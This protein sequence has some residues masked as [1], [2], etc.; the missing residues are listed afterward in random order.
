MGNLMISPLMVSIKNVKVNQK[1][2]L[3]ITIESFN[4]S[5]L[6]EQII[7]N[8]HKLLP[9]FHSGTLKNMDTIRLMPLC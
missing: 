2:C 6:S 3:G 1:R 9:K 7:N 4:S 5:S 8:N